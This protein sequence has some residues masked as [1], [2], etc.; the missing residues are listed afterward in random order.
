MYIIHLDPTSADC[1]EKTGQN[2]MD[3]RTLIRRNGPTVLSSVGPTDD[4]LAEI[5]NARFPP[6]QQ[7]HVVSSSPR[8]CQENTA[9][10][11][12]ARP[13]SGRGFQVRVLST[14]EVDL[15]S[16]G[17]LSFR[18]VVR[19]GASVERIW[20][21]NFTRMCSGSEEGSY[22]RRMDFYSTQR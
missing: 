22:L 9:R 18:S 3:F 12:Q 14:F 7:P 15:S 11:R 19:L 4:A 6:S 17:S 16:L 13:D 5:K 10:I 2:M 21:N 20:H 8:R 1:Q